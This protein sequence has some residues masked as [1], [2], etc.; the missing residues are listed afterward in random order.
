M[1]QSASRRAF[2]LRFRDERTHRAL[3]HAARELGMSMNELAE[4]AIEHELAAVGAELEERLRRTV[5]L[6]GSYRAADRMADARDFARAEVEED[7]P[8]RSRAA[9]PFDDPVGVGAVFA[10]PVER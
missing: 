5:R 3:Q 1:K 10:D 9:E 4:R 7:D 2:T 8:L 6:L